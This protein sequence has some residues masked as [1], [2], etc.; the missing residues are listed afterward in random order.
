MF[1]IV[2]FDVMIVAYIEI[3]SIYG[4]AAFGLAAFGMRGASP[5]S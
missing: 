5:T 2:K 1:E 4:I 3:M